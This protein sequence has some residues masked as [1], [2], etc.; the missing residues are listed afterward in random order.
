M[1]CPRTEDLSTYMDQ[2]L[3]ARAQAALQQHLSTC[4]VC[5]Q[6]LAALQALRQDLQ[7]LPSPTLGFDLAAQLQDRLP[8]RQHP[9]LQRP[10]RPRARV[11][12]SSARS[13]PAPRPAR[14]STSP[15]PP[16]SPPCCAS[17]PARTRPA[18]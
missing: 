14:S 9:A 13:D 8:L 3:P 10:A 1:N 4:P 18:C 6:Q 5:R 17:S 11:H 2:T 15:S 7:A 16:R 12:G